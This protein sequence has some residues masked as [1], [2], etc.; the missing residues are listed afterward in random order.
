VD[1]FVQ[2]T[3][4]V[5]IGNI[6]YVIEYGGTGGHIWKITLPAKSSTGHRTA[7]KKH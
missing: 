7:G 5:L 2:P 3:D 6:A 1:G 4:A